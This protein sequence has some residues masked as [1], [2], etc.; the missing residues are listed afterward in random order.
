ME[1]DSK[2]TKVFEGGFDIFG[3]SVLCEAL[4]EGFRK[5][6]EPIDHVF[7]GLEREENRFCYMDDGFIEVVFVRQQFLA[8][9][10]L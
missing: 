5:L 6:E 7:T 1:G 4:K 3:L 8:H 10:S 2:K 9:G